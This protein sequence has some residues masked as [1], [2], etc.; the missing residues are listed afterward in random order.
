MIWLY[1][2]GIGR[3]RATALNFRHSVTFPV[4]QAPGVKRTQCRLA[5]E[6]PPEIKLLNESS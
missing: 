3:P 2:T 5:L 4:P 6:L 1:S